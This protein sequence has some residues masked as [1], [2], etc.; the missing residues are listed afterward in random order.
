VCWA[1]AKASRDDVTFLLFRFAPICHGTPQSVPRKTKKACRIGKPSM[2][3][4]VSNQ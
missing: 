3:F 4:D 1:A 2:F